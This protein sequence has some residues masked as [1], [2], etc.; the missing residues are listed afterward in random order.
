MLA[1]AS[2]HSNVSC[3]K[4][5]DVQSTLTPPKPLVSNGPKFCN[6]GTGTTNGTNTDCPVRITEPEPS[7]AGYAPAG[8]S[9][10]H[11]A[12][13]TLSANGDTGPFPTWPN[14]VMPV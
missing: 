8:G 12:F 1:L 2:S 7:A 6:P 13:T 9:A 4:S 5:P 10:Y 3:V 14:T 11:V